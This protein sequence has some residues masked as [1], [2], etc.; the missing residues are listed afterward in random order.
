MNTLIWLAHKRFPSRPN[1]SPRKSEVNFWF[2]L[3]EKKTTD[4]SY[5]IIILYFP[6]PIP[7]AKKTSENPS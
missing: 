2:Y 6:F 3:W 5:A 4:F 7:A 1:A